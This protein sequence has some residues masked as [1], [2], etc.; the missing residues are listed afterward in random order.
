MI[1][2]SKMKNTIAISL[3][4]K[5]TLVSC[6]AQP[7]DQTSVRMRDAKPNGDGSKFETCRPRADEFELHM[8]IGCV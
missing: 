4:G 8:V 7:Q 6:G 2:E 5:L 1:F 3:D